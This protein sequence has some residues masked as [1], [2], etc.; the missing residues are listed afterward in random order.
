MVAAAPPPPPQE[1]WITRLL[2]LQAR[3]LAREENDAMVEVGLPVR[4]R[5][6]D[7]GCGNGEVARRIQEQLPDLEIDGI[8]REGFLADEAARSLAH[9]YRTDALTGWNPDE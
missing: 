9:L 8:E 1:H 5:V 6:L 3:V 7:V 4:G 2:R